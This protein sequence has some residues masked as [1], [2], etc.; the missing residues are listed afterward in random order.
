MP[1]LDTTYAPATINTKL[2]SLSATKIYDATT[3]LS[4]SQVTISTG[5]SGE[6]LSYT[7][8][9]GSDSNVATS[10][11]YISSI[12]LVDSLNAVASN[13]HLPTLNASNAP[14]TIQPKTVTLSATKTYDGSTVLTGSQVT[15][16]TGISGQSLS[17][18]GA[19]VSDANVATIG[20]YISAI[21]LTNGTG[22]AS[23]YQ[24][25]SL[26]GTYSPVTINPAN[27]SIS[28]SLE[29]TG[30]A[31]IS[32]ANLAITGVNSEVITLS[33]FATMAS[34]H[35]QTGQALSSISDLVITPGS[36]VS[37]SNYNALSVSNTSVTVTPKVITLTPPSFNKV[38]D[39]TASYVL[40]SSDLESFSTQLL[41]SDRVTSAI[42]TF[43]GNSSSAGNNKPITISSITISDGNNGQNYQV[44]VANGTTGNI[45]PAPLTIRATNDAK[46]VSQSDAS[47]YA[48]A[49]VSGFVNN[50]NISAIT[51]TLV[52]SRSDPTNNSAGTYVLTPSGYGVNGGVNGNY[53][54][55]YQAGSYTIVPAD[56]L[57]IRA[58]SSVTYG[59]TPSYNFTAAYLAGSN[60]L[61]YIGNATTSSTSVTHTV[62]G[63]QTV[64]LNDGHSGGVVLGLEALNP[65]LSGSGSVSVGQYNITSSAN[66]N[67]VG[68]NYSQLIVLGQLSVTPLTITVPT[69][70]GTSISKVY[71]GNLYLNS[72]AINTSGSSNQ[73]ITG[74]LANIAATGS[75]SNKNVGTNKAVTVNFALSGAD[76]NNYILSASQ[77]SG[78]YGE[79]TQLN[80]VTFTGTNGSN[81][82]SSSSWA[83]GA[84]PEL[85]NVANVV[86]PA[87]KSVTY[88]AGV[89][90]PVTTNLINSGLVDFNLSND[91]TIQMNIS[92]SGNL[93]FSGAGTV[94]LTGTNTYTGTNTIASG[95]R[96]IA[97]SD[98]ALG[99]NP[100][101]ITNGGYFGTSSGV[102]LP[103]LNI[104]GG[105]V[106]LT[107]DISTIGS[108]T[109][110]DIVLA[111]S[112]TTNTLALSTDN[113]N[114]TINGTI[115][116]SADK[117]SS[118]SADAGTATVTLGNSIG[119]LHRF[120]ALTVTGGNIY[121]LA[122]ILT[123]TT[124]TYNGSVWIGDRTYLGQAFVEG[125]LY[126]SYS[127]YFVYGSGAAASSYDYKNNDSRYVRTLISED[128][129]IRFNGTVD[130][131]TDYTHTLLV[132]AITAS[133][134]P[135]GNDVPIIRFEQPVSF[136]Q[137]LYSLNIQ[138]VKANPQD[139]CL[140]CHITLV[141]GANTYAGQTYKAGYVEASASTTGGEVVF[142]V[143][144]P[145]AAVNFLLPLNGQGQLDLRNPSSIDALTFNGSTNF[146]SA[147]NL[148]GYQN[149]GRGPSFQDALG[150]L[151]PQTANDSTHYG[152]MLINKKVLSD[153]GIE[154][155][156]V[157]SVEV[158]DIE[159][160]TDCQ[161]DV[162]DPKKI[163]PECKLLPAI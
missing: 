132:A 18:S 37:L 10:N 113:S 27:L 108:Q 30:S 149:W 139:T 145:N 33:G 3:S 78:N 129:Q 47:G 48:G 94:T 51:G 125:F 118:F 153:A 5:I 45:T 109:Y 68:N 117:I 57:I 102:Q 107:S 62:A 80:S 75:Y 40:S 123:G 77:V 83:G 89:L 100:T 97:G 64:T 88:D 59:S 104:S 155:D 90:G 58:S 7:G 43:T 66:T 16:G 50:E 31:V 60:T 150:A 42:A 76:K 38:Y 128:P 154:I 69:L 14:L 12:T 98:G 71:D 134:S 96:L 144:D 147:P 19:A 92:G 46:F 54:I 22:V 2:V 82:S 11:K 86:I 124:Q 49:N 163:S 142:S 146:S 135:T 152:Q 87:N 61:G 112:N 65:S 81:W 39:G 34:R 26:D 41:S 70:S 32:A 55:S 28:G 127:G 13:Y 114:I 103:S 140:E 158:N 79:I 99:S 95:S 17:Y 91:T 105:T 131:V 115:N 106:K 159:Q 1:T 72:Q 162:N 67:I 126:S 161:V 29:Y 9:I 23:N 15:I 160:A 20:K 8:A 56:G 119:N 116:D 52:I 36:G 24:L 93:N 53:Q 35:V 74:D 85:N 151:P 133:S 121:I 6:S 148:S 141:G 136:T 101:I 73:I 156:L 122:D 111:K 138:A 4:G 130:D 63:L 157:G 44:T 120:N 137:P 84:T 21:T 110:D 25:P 143:Y